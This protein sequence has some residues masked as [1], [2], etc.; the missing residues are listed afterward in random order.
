M[1]NKAPH[2]FFSSCAAF[3]L[4]FGYWA[5]VS[6]LDIISTA[7][8][9]VVPSTRI[10]SVQHLEGGIIRRIAVNEGQRVQKN[11]ILVELDPTASTADLGEL[12]VRLNSLK[13]EISRLT[14]ELNDQKTPK[15][16]NNLQLNFPQ[17]AMRSLEQ[18]NTRMKAHK[19]RLQKQRHLIV[20][21]ASI[22]N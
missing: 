8:G 2:I 15:I 6:T 4:A 19:S 3:C 16:H 10:K 13:F 12:Q 22:I 21:R 17:L 5:S 1:G 14:A 7:Q 20:Q 11:D 9:E 18:F